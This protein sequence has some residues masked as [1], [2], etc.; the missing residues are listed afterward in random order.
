MENPGCCLINCSYLEV[1][2]SSC[3]I[4]AASATASGSGAFCVDDCTGNCC[5]DGRWGNCCLGDCRPCCSSDRLWLLCLPARFRL[6]LLLLMLLLLL[7]FDSA[8]RT[9][10]DL[11]GN[12]IK[13]ISTCKLSSSAA[14]ILSTTI[15]T[16]FCVSRCLKMRSRTSAS[17]GVSCGLSVFSYV[18]VKYVIP[19]K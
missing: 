4:A 19:E 3:S 15:N 11:S 16:V 9:M 17:T 6:L 18:V 8:V 2:R 5:C 14:L 13:F 10:L 7:L 1:H 12:V